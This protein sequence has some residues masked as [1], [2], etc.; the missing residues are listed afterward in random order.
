MFADISGWKRSGLTQ[1]A[2]CVKRNMAYA[3][4]HYWY[5]RYREK[6]ALNQVKAD[7]GKFVPLVMDSANGSDGWCE[8]RFGNG[9]N[10]VF[11]QPVSPELLQALIG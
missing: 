6:E 9:T 5:K 7:E 3:T 4:F 2:W 10:L 11:R 8:I 1:K